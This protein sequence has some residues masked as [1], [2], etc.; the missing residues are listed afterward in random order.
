MIGQVPNTTTIQLGEWM[1]VFLALLTGWWLI[2]QIWTSHFPTVPVVQYMTRED[3]ENLEGKSDL[4]V[5]DVNL[6]I[7][8]VASKGAQEHKALSDKIDNLM[9]ARRRENQQIIESNNRMALEMTTAMGALRTDLAVVKAI[10]ERE[11]KKEDD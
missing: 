3:M 6:R 5:K 2:R 1:V 9:E 8:A 11:M 4:A 7:E 10:L